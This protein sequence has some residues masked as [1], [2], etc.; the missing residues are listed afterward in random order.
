MIMQTMYILE[1]FSI[2]FRPGFRTVKQLLSLSHQY[3]VLPIKKSWENPAARFGLASILDMR[4][5]RYFQ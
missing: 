5:F 3:M 4:G 1:K 2:F